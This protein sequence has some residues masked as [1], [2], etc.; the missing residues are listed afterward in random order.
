MYC[1]NCG[2][3]IDDNAQVCPE[4][5]VNQRSTGRSIQDASKSRL[6]VGLIG[7]FLGVLGIHNFILGYTNRGI[8]QLVLTI[9]GAVLTCGIVTFIVW[10]WTLIESIKILTGEIKEDA[11]GN[12][13]TD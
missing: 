12:P 8:T 5:G 13:L 4:C 3:E 9:V 10:I 7:I 6:V 11:Y 1:K 2:K